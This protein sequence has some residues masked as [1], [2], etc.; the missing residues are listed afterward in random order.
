MMDMVLHFAR[1]QTF[2]VAQG[3]NEEWSIHTQ[4]RGLDAEGGKQKEGK[5]NVRYDT[6][7]T[8]GDDVELV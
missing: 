1:I 2:F 4:Q 5:D 3:D 6:I 7:A 8:R